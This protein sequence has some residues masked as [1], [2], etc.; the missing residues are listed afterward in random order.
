[1]S[2]NVEII[3]PVGPQEPR[4]V[5][6]NSV[7]CLKEL[8]VPE[9]L[10]ARMHYVVDSE[11]EEQFER[12]SG[13]DEERVE[14]MKR[15]PEDGSR[16][17]AI[18]E[19][20]ETIQDPVYVAIFDVDSRPEENFLKACI[21]NLKSEGDLFMS[22]SPREILNADKNYV[23]KTIEA[24]FQFFNDIQTLYDSLNAFNHFNGPISVIDGEFAV[25]NGFREN[26]M[27]EDTDFTE[28]GYLEGRRAGITLETSL[29]EQ[30]PSGLDDLYF[31]K[32]RWMAGA[33]EGLENYFFRFLKSE[34]SFRVKTSW[35][36]SM[37][38]PFFA[39]VF[40]PLALLYSF[41]FMLHENSVLESVKKGV[42]LFF[43]S[44][45]ISFCGLVVIKKR[46]LGESIEW[47]SPE[48]ENL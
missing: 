46:L 11:N 18:N 2:S 27:C 44:W 48:R 12:V 1:M 9:N 22:S 3:V 17:G 23:T 32:V 29:G 19:A 15:Q 20:L 41:R 21:D 33:R 6:E 39:F 8:E 24:E 14:I 16:A 13:I 43:F 35:F 26:L 28:R 36:M 5:I 40:S 31:Q 4:E 38:M 10:E 30:A 34:N 25:K 47:R 42:L 7:D 45:F 37:L